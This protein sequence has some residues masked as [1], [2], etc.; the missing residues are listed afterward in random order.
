MP[1]ERSAFE[2]WLSREQSKLQR[3]AY[4]IARRTGLPRLEREDVYS[5]AME[6]IVRRLEDGE[7]IE[8]LTGYFIR[9]AEWVALDKRRT[10]RR[11]RSIAGKHVS[12]EEVLS[13]DDQRPDREPVDIPCEVGASLDSRVQQSWEHTLL[14]EVIEEM[15]RTARAVAWLRFVGGLPHWEIA[16]YL[17]L[18]EDQVKKQTSKVRRRLADGVER[19]RSGSW[20]RSRRALL[21][22]FALGEATEEECA[23]AGAHL[24]VC[25]GC[26]P[27]VHELRTARAAL[28]ALLPMPPAAEAPSLDAALGWCHE[29]RD[30][31]AD[32]FRSARTALYD[33]VARWPVSGRTGASASAAG[34]GGG[35]AKVAAVT[36]CVGG[37]TAVC[38]E[39]LVPVEGLIGA[40]PADS[41]K[42]ARSRPEPPVGHA[43]GDV[44]GRTQALE[45]R[46]EERRAEGRLRERRA[47]QGVAVGGASEAKP[48]QRVNS[49]E[50]FGFEGRESAPSTASS[51]D[52]FK[53][54]QSSSS[55]IRE[56]SSSSGGGGGDGEFGFEGSESSSG[57]GGSE[58]SELG[59]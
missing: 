1:Q 32:L 17:G 42:E 4:H 6:V 40:K 44:P 47:G 50:E 8:S 21:T 15:D 5:D 3:R 20:C 41:S 45:R 35:A 18:S 43:P 2:T 56:G 19:V 55:S 46:R 11:R 13:E 53:D 34:I 54:Y 28:P 33:T 26:R 57:S 22:R 48:E 23:K 36:L 25:S 30:S 24:A 7:T 39:T 38:I 37:G 12:L 14:G 31:G 51:G 10:L 49:A 27:L 9:T 59:P 16:A 52:E 58:S 29:L